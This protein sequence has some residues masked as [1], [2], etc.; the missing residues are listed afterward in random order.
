MYSPALA[1]ATLIP[2]EAAARRR[3][4]KHRPS[5]APMPITAAHWESH[6]MLADAR[7]APC[8]RAARHLKIRSW[9]FCGMTNSELIPAEL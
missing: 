7:K 8:C 5:R 9:T 3:A 6:N 1:N 2:V 4:Y